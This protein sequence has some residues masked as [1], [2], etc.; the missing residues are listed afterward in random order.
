AY[1]RLAG[2]AAG[3]SVAVVARGAVG[4]VRVRAN[5]CAGIAAAGDVALIGGGADDRIGARAQAHLAGVGLGA[6]VA[7]VARAP[8]GPGRVRAH[9]ARGIAH[10]GDVALVGGDAEDVA[11]ARAGAGLAGVGLRA[12]VAVVARAPVAL[13]RVRA[14]TAARIAHAHHVALIAGRAHH[15][16][17]AGAGA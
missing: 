6:G 8:V 4:L 3:A 5:A 9:A 11:G 17:G 15:R 7:V 2:V 12:G 13:G 1:A 16:V 10:A 14:E